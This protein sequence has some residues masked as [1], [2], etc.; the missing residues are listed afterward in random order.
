VQSPGCPGAAAAA[1]RDNGS[2]TWYKNGTP[3]LNTPFDFVLNDCKSRLWLHKIDSDG[4][5]DAQCIDPESGG[6]PNSDIG[7]SP[8]DLQISGNTANCP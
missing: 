7:T 3:H 4:T 6:S 8:H 1:R 5:T 2:E